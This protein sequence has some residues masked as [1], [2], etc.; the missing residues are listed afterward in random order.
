MGMSRLDL[1]QSCCKNLKASTAGP[2]ANVIARILKLSLLQLSWPPM[3]EAHRLRALHGLGPRERCLLWCRYK[4]IKIL[5]EQVEDSVGG[6]Q[7][8][9]KFKRLAFTRH[10][11]L[12]YET[13]SQCWQSQCKLR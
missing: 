1:Q 2:H 13:S 10:D 12:A 4:Q 5:P 3:S 6:D 8:A 9:Y 7:G 11:V